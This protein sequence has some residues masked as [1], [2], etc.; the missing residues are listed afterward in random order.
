MAAYKTKV[1]RKLE[2]YKKYP[3]RARADRI[4]GLV[5]IRF[6]LNRQGEVVSASVV[7]SSGQPILDDEVEA[8]LRRVNP[9][10]KFPDEL[11]DSTLT[12]TAPIQFALR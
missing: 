12:L 3:P 6:T 7:K 8:L 1:K 9:F 11:P 10:P 2:R 4:E 5:T